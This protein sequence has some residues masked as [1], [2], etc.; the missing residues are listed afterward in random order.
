MFYK[1]EKETQVSKV[2]ALLISSE[3]TDETTGSHLS[4]DEWI[5]VRQGKSLSEINEK[6][7]EWIH[8]WMD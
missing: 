3:A 1:I 4:L 6:Y 5:F 7:N 8:G 2:A